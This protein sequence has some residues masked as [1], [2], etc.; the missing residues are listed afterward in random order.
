MFS[1]HGWQRVVS[2]LAFAGVV[3]CVPPA[4]FAQEAASSDPNTGSL[5]VTAGA[6]LISTYMFRGIRQNSTGVAVWPMADFGMALY[7]GDGGLKSFALNI[8][9]WN[10]IHSGDTGADR[11]DGKMW[12]ESDFYA[13]LG[14]GFGGGVSLGTT[15]TAYT[16]PN[17]GFTTVKEIAVK[18]AVDDSGY[19]GRGALKP[20]GLVAIEFDTLPGVGQ[21]DGGENAG[22]Y[23]ELGVAPGWAATSVSL[24]FPVKLGMSLNDYYEGPDGDEKFGYVSVAGLV[25]VPLTGVPSRFGSW[26]VHGGVEVQALGDTTKAFNGDDAQ[27]VIGSFG[28]GL[29]Y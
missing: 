14:L 25:T 29:A 13:T 1:I 11:E 16:S 8:G 26:N 19:L 22:T 9:T 28:I 21:A 6:D 3:A 23:L 20:Y 17:S 2:A 27:R 15:Y 10:S 18:L 12:Y 4:A 5:T 7:S 24:A